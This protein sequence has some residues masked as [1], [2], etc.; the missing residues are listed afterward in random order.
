S[1]GLVGEAI[2]AEATKNRVREISRALA[3]VTHGYRAMKHALR[4][5]EEWSEDLASMVYGFVR[6]TVEQGGYT[7]ANEILRI[8]LELVPAGA[9]R[10][11]L[12]VELALINLRNNSGFLV[13]DLLPQFISLPP[14]MLRDFIVIMVGAHRVGMPFEHERATN[15]LRPS[16]D[17]DERTMQAF[18]SFML[19]IMTMRTDDLMH[20]PALIQ[21]SRHL[22]AQAPTDPAA[23]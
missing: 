22:F 4:G 15:L 23:L 21:Q 13:V 20:V 16:D 2:A 7:N 10:D 19:V 3:G 18:M 1:H 14:S 9:E 12:L 5:A 6:K 11:D 8:A 17:P